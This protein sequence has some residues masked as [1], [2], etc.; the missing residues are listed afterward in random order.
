MFTR[1]VELM[2]D[3]NM[4]VVFL[5]WWKDQIQGQHKWSKLFHLKDCLSTNKLAC[6]WHSSS[7]S[8]FS[9]H[10]MLFSLLVKHLKT[11][12]S[13]FQI[14]STMIVSGDVYIIIFKITHNTP[15]SIVLAGCLWETFKVTMT[16]AVTKRASAMSTIIIFFCIF[17]K[18]RNNQ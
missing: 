17:K 14:D 7:W 18:M 1:K 8:Q 4:L 5:P 10:Q 3:I 12:I 13:S 9:V 11:M 16:I 15:T 6:T 2:R